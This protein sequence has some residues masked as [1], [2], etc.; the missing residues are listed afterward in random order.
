M[1][2]PDVK[3]GNSVELSKIFLRIPL[4]RQTAAH[5]P[6]FQ[7]C[8][9]QVAVYGPPI[10][11]VRAPQPPT[12]LTQR[13]FWCGILAKRPGRRAGAEG[14]ECAGEVRGADGEGW[15]VV[16]AS[17]DGGGRRADGGRPLGAWAASERL[18]SECRCGR[19]RGC[20]G[21]GGGGCGFPGPRCSRRPGCR[22]PERLKV[23]DA[24]GCG[25]RCPCRWG[26]CRCR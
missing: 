5:H 11:G 23:R 18:T 2:R 15:R 6:P 7:L 22:S 25:S 12:Q 8:Q 17:A 1:I 26:F 20:W 21:G 14:G 19:R 10:S 24:E 13:P 4:F 16:G 3:V 9:W